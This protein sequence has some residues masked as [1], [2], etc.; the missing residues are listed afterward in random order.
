MRCIQ[1]FLM[2]MVHSDLL[3]NYDIGQLYNVQIVI[4]K[5]GYQKRTFEFS[6]T[7]TESGPFVLNKALN[8][9]LSKID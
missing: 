8:L 6:V 4:E 9:S 2:T 7:F 3:E 5:A 1:P